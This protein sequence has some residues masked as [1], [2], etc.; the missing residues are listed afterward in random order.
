MRILTSKSLKQN[1]AVAAAVI[2][3]VFTVIF[4]E[5]VRVS[6]SDAVSNCLT[7]IIPCIF[8]VTVISFFILETGIPVKI[9]YITDKILR[10]LFGLSGNCLEGV[11][12]GLTGGYNT[13]V[14]CAVKLKNEKTIKAE[15]AK[16]L[17][18]FFT[19]PGISFTVMLAGTTLSGSLSTGLRLYAETVFL[20]FLSAYIYNKFNKYADNIQITENNKRISDAFVSAVEAGS[21]VILSVSFNIIIFSCIVCIIVSLLPFQGINEIIRLLSEV[22]FAVTYSSSAYPFYITAGILTFGGLCIFIQNLSDL[23]KLSVKP[24]SFLL[25]RIIHSVLITLAEFIFSRLFPESVYTS[26]LY[27]VKFTASENIT[28]TLALIFLCAVYLISV[29]NIKRMKFATKKVH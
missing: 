10:N 7:V 23:K 20:N 28:G 17:A 22:S 13:A 12:L 4:S 19:N 16:R 25:I 11:I 5:K 1:T 14:K 26:A 18:I 21:S 29:R 2:L 24:S 6:A 15:Q 8:P 3:L 9:K 27:S